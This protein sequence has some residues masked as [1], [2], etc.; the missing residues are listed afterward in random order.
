VKYIPSSDGVG[1]RPSCPDCAVNV[2]SSIELPRHP[3]PVSLGTL[4]VSGDFTLW[5]SV[6]GD[7]VFA[8]GCDCDRTRDCSCV[9]RHAEFGVLLICRERP[10]GVKL[11]PQA[12]H[13]MT[14]KD[15]GVK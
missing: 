4:V 5:T 11:R 8:G 6:D 2:F 12:G 13:R 15:M 10:R 7:P 9:R 14:G 3:L 1:G